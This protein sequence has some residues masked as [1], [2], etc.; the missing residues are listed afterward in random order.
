MFSEK[1][2]WVKIDRCSKELGV[3]VLMISVILSVKAEWFIENDIETSTSADLSF[4][5]T[6]SPPLLFRY[7][8]LTFNPHRIHYDNHW[9]QE[10]EGH[11]ALLMHGPLTATLLVE[12]AGQ[13]ATSRGK[14]LQNFRYRATN[15]LY[16]SQE[17]RLSGEWVNGVHESLVMEAVQEGRVGMTASVTMA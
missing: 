7:S 3:C 9:T 15:P 10:V 4:K 14:T 11:P 12:I 17:V 6:P 13:A 2:S 1:R 8:A 5:F 16:V